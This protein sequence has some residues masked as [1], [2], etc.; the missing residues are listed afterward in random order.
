MAN[1]GPDT[2]GSQFFIVYKASELS[3]N[4]TPFGEVRSGIEVVDQVAAGGQDDAYGAGNGG[5]PRTQ[6]L[7]RSV[8][9]S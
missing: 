1:A 9:V 6:V 2:N 5:H 4:Y 3:A 7:I 8:T